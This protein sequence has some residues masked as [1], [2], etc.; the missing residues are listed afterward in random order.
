[1]IVVADASPLNY[2]IQI[3]SDALLHTLFGRVLVPPAVMDELRHPHA[4]RT[5]ASW[6]LQV[7]SWLEVRAVSAS[8]DDS[9]QVLD[10]GE[11]EAILLAQET[12]ADLLLIDE[13]H[14]RLEAGRRGIPTTG[15]LGVLLAAGARGLLDPESAFQR[16]VSETSFR[17]ATDVREH[18][19]ALCKKTRAHE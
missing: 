3:G 16:L 17:A 9:L 2:L 6:L 7:P 13:R 12:R 1:M 5:V 15:T 18:F 11:R 10:P 4:P 14:G 8:L 19:L